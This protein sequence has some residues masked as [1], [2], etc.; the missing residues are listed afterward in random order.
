MI[1]VIDKPL[2]AGEVR[3]FLGKPYSEMIKFVVDI[4]K[5]RLALGG[6]LHADTEAI[7]LEQGS[8][9]AD[10]WGGNYH[11]QR[12]KAGRI[13]YTSMINIRPSFGNAALEVKDEKVRA[14]MKT[15]VEKLLP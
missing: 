6:E 7:L 10:L 9:P 11:P 4:A 2:S 13:E 14:K 12:Q 8:R 3:E 1:K 15:I 5:S